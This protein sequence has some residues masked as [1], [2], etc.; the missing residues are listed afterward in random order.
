MVVNVPLNNRLAALDANARDSWPEWRHYLQRWT[1]WNHVRSAAAA[2]GIACHDAGGREARMS[3]VATLVL[4]PGL[5]GTSRDVR[6]AAGDRCRRGSGRSSSPTQPRGPMATTTCCRWCSTPSAGTPRFHILGWSFGGPLA[7]MAAVG[8]PVGGAGDHP[9]RILRPRPAARPGALALR[10]P[11]ARGCHH[12]RAAA[13]ARAGS[14]LSDRGSAP[15]PGGD[16]ATGR[17]PRAL[18]ADQGRPRRRCAPAP[19]LVCRAGPLC[20]QLAGTG[21]SRATTSMTSA[22]RRARARW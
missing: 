18:D 8:E 15:G 19:R 6:A 13:R 20:R 5:D 4:L 7:L 17:R 10:L 12:P 21:S 22:R 2:A 3:H 9:V 11:S 14:R 1:W 16:L